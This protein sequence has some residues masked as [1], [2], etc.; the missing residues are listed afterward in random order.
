M[1]KR[2]EK[3]R[4]IPKASHVVRPSSSQRP[5]QT[6]SSISAYIYFKIKTRSNPHISPNIKTREPSISSL[7]SRHN[8]H[9]F[10]LFF[11]VLSYKKHLPTFGCATRPP[12]SPPTP[13][14]FESGRG[15]TKFMAAAETELSSSMLFAAPDSPKKWPKTARKRKKT[16]LVRR[17]KIKKIGT[18]GI[19]LGFFFFFCWGLFWLFLFFWKG[20][21]FCCFLWQWQCDN[22][23]D[24]MG[25]S[26]VAT[27]E[28]GK[29][30]DDGTLPQ[31][32]IYGLKIASQALISL[33][34]TFHSPKLPFFT[35]PSHFIC[36][37]NSQPYLFFLHSSIS[38]FFP[39][40]F[41]F[42][43]VV[44][45]FFS[46]FFSNFSVFFVFFLQFFGK[47]NADCDTRKGRNSDWRT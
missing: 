29:S 14:G 38:P 32:F 16:P 39:S 42:F 40:F 18:R 26:V 45:H 27:V 33:G 23:G 28:S 31:Q 8:A 1:K 3:E 22:S 11:A 15:G 24:W 35:F 2:D 30:F 9:F 43:F 4:E 34:S 25:G 13:C 6:Q 20:W 19:F 5:P 36:F 21:G 10:E 47:K 46:V 12:C 41:S 17:K 37:L 7:P 44:F